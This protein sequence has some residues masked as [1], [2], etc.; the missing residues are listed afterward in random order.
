MESYILL[1]IKHFK[2][3]IFKSEL[4]YFFTHIYLLPSGKE[5]EQSVTEI[6]D[7]SLRTKA[8]KI[9]SGH[10]GQNRF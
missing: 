4:Q 8:S 9:N 1:Q 3:K 10:T 5:I 2:I 7:E 6:R